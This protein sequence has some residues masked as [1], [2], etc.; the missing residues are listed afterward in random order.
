MSGTPTAQDPRV[1]GLAAFLQALTDSCAADTFVRLQVSAPT[2]EAAPVERIVGRLVDVRSGRHLSCT[3][4]EARR[5]TTTNVPVAEAAAFVEA[6]LRA[7][8]RSALLATTTADWQLRR[9]DDGWRLIRHRPQTTTPP[10]RTHDGQKPT[11]LGPAAQP[12]LHA[13]GITDDHGRPRSQLAHKHTQIDRYVEILAHLARECGWHQRPADEAPLRFVDVGCGK[14]HLTFA[15][16]HLGR[17]LLGTAVRVLGVEARAD[18]VERANEQARELTGDAL[19]FAC[20]DI[21][22]APLPEVDALIALHACNTATDHAIRRGIEA[23][24]QLIVVAPCCHQEVR[25][26][27]G[28]PEPLAPVLAH[29]LMA[30]RMAEWATDGLRA[31][32]LERAGYRTKVIE[33][34]SSEHTA[35]NVMIAAVRSQQPPSAS[36]RAEADAAIAAF[37]TFF[38]ITTQALDGLHRAAT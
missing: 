37:R 14:G 6:Q 23:K 33:F 26:Q 21:A 38:G 5:D 36:Q 19:Q 10:P 2:P 7:Q 20:G 4:R 35:K 1:T 28:R 24:A 25:P 16:W 22:T 15:A 27:L 11:L 31:L 18:L 13:L 34:V 12:W 3:L 9:D 32:V 29:G 30:E 17:H 8:F